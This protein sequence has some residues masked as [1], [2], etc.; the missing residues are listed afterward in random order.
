MKEDLERRE[1]GFK[2]RR[3]EEEDEAEKRERE[4]RRLAED[5]K[6]RRREMEEK[7]KRSNEEEASVLE[8]TAAAIPTPTP[9]GEPE[10]ERRV[11]IRFVREG[12]GLSFNETTLSSAFSRYGKIENVY[13]LRERKT[14]LS[15][16]KHRKLVATAAITYE[17]AY[18]A[19]LLLA[20]KDNLAPTYF[21]I[22]GGAPKAEEDSTSVAPSTPMASPALKK[23]F[24]ASIGSFTGGAASPAFSFSPLRS[25]AASNQDVTMERLRAA[26]KEKERRRLEEEIRKEEAAAAAE[27]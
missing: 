22:N 23:S 25:G 2:R 3:E 21:D 8:D 19:F 11:F 9:T 10:T 5:G 27:G 6:R 14:R 12:E 24:R 18:D 13:I 16:E 7:A 20:D 15:G 4:L 26:Q 1:S 17:R